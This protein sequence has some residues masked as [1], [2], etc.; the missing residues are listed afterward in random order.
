MAQHRANTACSGCHQFMDPIGLAIEDFD[1]VGRWRN[2]DADDSVVDAAG[3]LPSGVT[4][5]GIAGLRDALLDRPEMFATTVT[6]KLLT[7][8]LGRGLDYY[9]APTVRAILRDARK[10]DYRFSS[11]ITGVVQSTPFQMRRTP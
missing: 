8:A 3:S 6:E 2:R 4:F 11:L 1:A 7:Y 9:D 5:R 10:K